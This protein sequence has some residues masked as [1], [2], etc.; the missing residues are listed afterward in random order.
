MP[1]NE[2]DWEMFALERLSEPNGWSPMPGKEIAPGAMSGFGH[3]SYASS[4]APQVQRESWDEIAIPSRMRA[5]L[6]RLNP[7][8]PRRFLDQAL[9]EILRPRSQDAISENKRIHDILTGGYR[10]TYIEDGVEHTPSIR[11]VSPREDDN[12]LLAVNQV[13]VRDGEIER[14]FDVV[15]YLNGMPVAIMELKKAGAACA[16]VSAAHAQLAQYVRDLPMAFRFCVLVV[17]SDGVVAKYGTPFTSLNHFSPWN[18]DDD[19]RAVGVGESVTDSLVL[20]PD[21]AVIPTPLD[22]TIDGLFNPERFG[23]LVRG[24]VSFEQGDEG[25]VKRIA[26]PHQYFAVT[27]AVGST[28]Q[29]VETDGRAGVV[30]HTQGSGKSME[31][32]LYANAV[33]RHPKLFNPTIVVVTDRTELDGQLFETFKGS[34]LLASTPQRIARRAELRSELELRQSGGILFTTLQKFGLT[35]EEK[36]AG[37]THPVLSTRRN[38][39]LIVDEAHRSHYDNLDGYAAHLKAALPNATLIA[40]TGTPVAEADRDTQAVFGDVI[41]VYDL[42]RAVAD[43]ATVPVY[44]EQRLIKVGFADDIDAETIDATADE[45]MTGLDDAERDRMQRDVARINAVYGSPARLKLLAGDLVSHWEARRDAMAEQVRSAD[46][47]ETPE[48][49]PGKALVVCATRAI[50]ANLYDEIVALRP[51]WHSDATAEG[52]IKVV[53]SGDA[54]DVDPIRQ[55]VRRE[56]ENAVIRKRLKTP[57]DELEIVI[58][59]DMMLTGFDAPPL[60][61]LYLDRPMRGALLMQTLAR[62]NRTFRGKNAGL[63]VGYAPVAENLK[64]ALAEYT[65]QDQ[66][67]LPVGRTTEDAEAV[68]RELLATLAGLV[69]GSGWRSRLAAGTGAARTWIDAVAFTVA[70][71]RNPQTPGN[72]PTADGEET[73]GAEFRR[74]AAALSRA[75][76]LAGRSAALRDVEMDARFYEEVRVWMGKLDAEDRQARGE[77]IPDEVQRLLNQLLATSVESDE[78]MDVYA[79]A[80]LERPRLDRLDH[81]YLERAQSSPHPQLAIEALRALVAA[82]TRKLTEGNLVRN[83]MFSERLE[84]VMIR[85]TNS[86]LTSAEV[87]QVLF[88]MAREL[89]AEDER[90]AK[91]QLN[92]DETAFWD[93]L[94]DNDS[95]QEEIGD[96]TLATIARKLHEILKRDVKTDWTVRDDVRAKIRTSV[97][98][99]LISYHYP[100]DKQSEAVVLVMQQMEAMAPRYAA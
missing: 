20:R 93:A 51:D 33:A 86:N 35:S 63:L 23:Q 84:E 15:L 22:V 88:E 95:A 90:G 14:R 27:K 59:K 44:F 54:T 55:H 45:V 31:M 60:H 42:T 10:L 24:F 81:S 71:L 49:A 40:F 85:Y 69:D 80:G 94:R 36:K 100:P 11:L 91:Y 30:W 28:V 50:C 57:A 19:G 12:E 1:A 79:A 64:A 7:N 62:V 4:G 72:K 34:Q 41:D 89:A 13:T 98:R 47:T 87:I 38:I 29:A 96:E 76:A 99:L 48:A 25:L 75:W 83:R 39:V 43:G 92:R 8:V 73:R 26:K 17:V 3:P 21:E 6:R 53:Y 77:P 82:E 61:T 2:A 70:W 78:V 74:R 46:A 97:K 68:T 52:R 37:R 65:V 16:D 67:A 56:P 58:V 32:E 18:V 9:E 66:E 5:A